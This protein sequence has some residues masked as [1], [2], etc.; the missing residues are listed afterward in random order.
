MRRVVSERTIKLRI[1]S[2]LDKYKDCSYYYMPVPG[3]Y[4]KQTLDYLGFVLGRGF[5]I[6]AKAEDGKVTARQSVTIAQILQAGAKVFVINDEDSLAFFAKWMDEVVRE[7]T[8][9]PGTRINQ[10]D[11]RRA[12]PPVTIS[13][14]GHV[15]PR[16]RRPALPQRG[17][18]AGAGG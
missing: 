17:R 16:S 1:K 3:G 2:V 7:E 4:G 5:A 14:G 11:H 18:R 9:G 15:T 8:N 6:E 12:E 10:T 13:R